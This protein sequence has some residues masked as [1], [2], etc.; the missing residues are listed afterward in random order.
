MP[1]TTET[2]ETF[3][4]SEPSVANIR[5]NIRLTI[6]SLYASL[7]GA[8]AI[9]TTRELSE[10]Q[11]TTVE[12]LNVAQMIQDAVD[13]SALAHM[14]PELPAS[15]EPPPGS[16]QC[17]ITMPSGAPDRKDESLE[18]PR[19]D[20]VRS[21]NIPEI[22]E[23]G[24]TRMRALYT[25]V[26]TELNTDPAATRLTL[27]IWDEELTEMEKAAALWSYCNPQIPQAAQG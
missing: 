6:A 22:L 23:L 26:L 18:T 9:T 21:M 1:N 25:C 16:R 3:E 8:S 14:R 13:Q 12:L 10:F 7:N 17:S 5:S 2:S 27:M 20:L 24:A 4:T 19:I 11:A 15:Q